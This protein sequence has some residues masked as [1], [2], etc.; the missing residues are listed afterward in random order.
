M[1]QFTFDYT[2]PASP[3]QAKKR[4]VTT[5]RH[6]IAA[7]AGLLLLLFLLAAVLD[8][9]EDNRLLVRQNAIQRLRYDSLL[10]A[11]LHADRQLIRLRMEKARPQTGKNM[12]ARQAPGSWKF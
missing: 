10:A 6:E 7:G 12:D 9:R 1:A 8:Y 5:V 4:P 2:D 3:F 11:K